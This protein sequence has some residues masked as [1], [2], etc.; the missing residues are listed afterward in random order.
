M[1]STELELKLVLDAGAIARLRRKK[2]LSTLTAGK[3]E[4]RRLMTIYYDSPDHR[5]HAH[6]IALRVRKT[7]NRHILTI[8]AG[9]ALENGL[10]K[11]LELE[12]DVTSFQPDLDAIEPCPLKAQVEATLDGAS[13]APLFE[14]AIWRTTRQLKT[15]SGAAFE[16]AI[17]KGE[18]IAGESREMIEEVELEQGRGSPVDLLAMA[19]ELFGDLPFQPSTASKAQRGFELLREEPIDAQLS[20]GATAQ[21]PVSQPSRP[22]LE[23]GQSAADAL[24]LAGGSAA[25]Q[26]LAYWS[27]LPDLLDPEVPHQLRVG[28]RRLRTALRMLKPALD[29]PG[30]R[31]LANDARDL[32]RHVGAL[33]DADVLI[34]DIVA[35]AIAAEAAGPQPGAENLLR[36][37][38]A[39]R[40][41]IRAEVRTQAASPD[42][43]HFKLNCMLFDFAV[44]RAIGEISADTHASPVKGIARKALKKTWRKSAAWGQRIDDL[45][46][47]ERHEM[48]KSLKSL[49]YATEFFG[50]LFPQEQAGA[51][52]KQLKKLQSVFGYLNDVALTETLPALAAAQPSGDDATHASIA[53]ISNW[54]RSRAKKAWRDARRRWIKL[55][56]SPHFWQR[57]T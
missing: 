55:D 37:L 17:D 19:E 43:S 32:G 4:R 31:G 3:P 28:L 24:R 29:T 39:H 15:A 25:R 57:K 1:S 52:L 44:D 48:R 18:V 14:T 49:R 45:S 46:T 40:E 12:R 8:K 16:L 51:F 56:Q 20:A 7:G 47:E 5:L 33:R 53:A 35:P 30:L 38:E 6:G 21:L 50:P 42:W 34:V 54:H 27:V 11:A 2:V 10:S 9:R 13:L 36:I 22:A 26:A 23:P 41:R